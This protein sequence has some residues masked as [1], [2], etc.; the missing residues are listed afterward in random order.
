M[1][2]Y[3]FNFLLVV[4]NLGYN[5]SFLVPQNNGSQKIKFRSSYSRSGSNTT[6]NCKSNRG[7]TGIRERAKQIK[8]G[9]AEE[10]AERH[11]AFSEHARMRARRS[12]S[13][14]RDLFRSQQNESDMLSVAERCQRETSD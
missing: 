3:G 5:Q 10:A 6:S 12:R 13:S 4:F 11:V 14:A 9:R 7:L 2:S 1:K 8:N